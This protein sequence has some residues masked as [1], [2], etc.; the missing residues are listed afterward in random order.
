MPGCIEKGGR[1]L[2]AGEAAGSGP[3]GQNEGAGA[4]NVQGLGAKQGQGP[5]ASMAVLNEGCGTGQKP[6][7]SV[8]IPA[9]LEPGN[10]VISLCWPVGAFRV[11]QIQ[12]HPKFGRC[13]PADWGI[14]PSYFHHGVVRGTKDL[15][16]NSSAVIPLT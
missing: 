12:D 6:K 10:Q 13:S 3:A 7:A 5:E 8:A 1:P 14:I 4:V 2:D 9:G 15:L 16:H 11:C